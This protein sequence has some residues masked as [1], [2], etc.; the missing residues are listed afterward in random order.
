MESEKRAKRPRIG[1]SN[2]E[3]MTERYE[4]VEYKRGGTT[5]MKEATAPIP[6]TGPTTMGT[7][8]EAMARIVRAGME[9]T[10]RV[11]MATIAA[12]PTTTGRGTTRITVATTKG[13][14]AINRA[15]TARTNAPTIPNRIVRAGMET[16]VRADMATTAT[17]RT[18]RNNAATR[19]TTAV[20]NASSMSCPR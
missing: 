3:G 9:T 11:D 1:V 19:T 2:R 7:V 8:R 4:K 6:T 18:G 5:M 13:V 17:A 12:I 14:R 16:T 10:V 15:L 20:R